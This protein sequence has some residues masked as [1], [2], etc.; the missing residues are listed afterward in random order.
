ML[1]IRASLAFVQRYV[2]AVRRYMGWE[3]VFLAYNCVNALT[4]ALIGVETH[5]PRRVLFLV[6]GA[7]LWG[8]LAIIF[9]E[10]AE[11]IAWER[12][13][14][15]LEY[16]FMAP[17]HRMT[18]VVG[19]CMSAVVYGIVRTVIVMVVVVS[20]LHLPWHQADIGSAMVVLCV[21]SLPLMG[22]GVL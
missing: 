17:I 4:I 21:S 5:D 2:H 18:H 22:L 11:C 16:T 1:E 15:T 6:I 14:G 10:V 8:F 3:L 13:E 12:W 7:V 9:H 19:M 20:F